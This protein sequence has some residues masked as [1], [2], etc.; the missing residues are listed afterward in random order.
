DGILLSKPPSSYGLAAFS[1]L[2]LAFTAWRQA[3]LYLATHLPLPG[4]FVVAFLLLGLAQVSM[5]LGPVW[6]LAWWEYHLLMYAAVMIALGTLLL[7]YGRG[8][9]LRHILDGALE[10]K[11]DQGVEIEN[12]D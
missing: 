1:G 4:A 5:V 12:V 10:L 11:L 8:R 6:T 9:P 7:E 2:L 3:R